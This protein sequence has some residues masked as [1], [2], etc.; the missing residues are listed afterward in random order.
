ML[1]GF[2]VDSKELITNMKKRLV[3]NEYPNTIDP[4]IKK[5][6]YPKFLTA[7]DWQ[8]DHLDNT[9]RMIADIR[10]NRIEE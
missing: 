5:Y 6:F 7:V 1:R 8:K 2:V 10:R 3:E 4:K 9:L